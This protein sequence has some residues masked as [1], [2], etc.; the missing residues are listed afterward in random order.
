MQVEAEVAIGP[1]FNTVTNAS[2]ADAAAPTVT[3]L[4]SASSSAPSQTAAILPTGPTM[5]PT[6]T[7]QCLVLALENAAF[8]KQVDALNSTAHD[9][10]F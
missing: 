1:E 2:H 10:R 4:A 9:L 5:T 8:R 3:T 6:Q 7:P